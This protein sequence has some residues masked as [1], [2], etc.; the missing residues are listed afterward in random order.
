MRRAWQWGSRVDHCRAVL[1]PGFAPYEQY[2]TRGKQGPWSDVYACAATLYYL[3]TGR[4]PPEASE[5]IESPQLESPSAFAP[6]LTPDLSDAIVYGLGFRPEE[7][8]QSARAFADVIAGRAAAPLGATQRVTGYAPIGASGSAEIPRTIVDSATQLRT[9]A[10]TELAPPTTGRV[11]PTGGRVDPPPTPPLPP[12]PP[13][14][15]S[16]TRRASNRMPLFAGVA[17]LVL[18]VATAW[19][20]GLFEGKGNTESDP[21]RREEPE[22][23]QPLPVD[24]TK[25]PVPTPR[26]VEP[27]KSDPPE[28]AKPA[29]T[30]KTTTSGTTGT[31]SK[32]EI[33][34]SAR[35]NAPPPSVQNTPVTPAPPPTAVLVVMRGEDPDDVRQAE[36]AILRALV[37]R[38][39]LHA[40][41][42]DSLSLMRGDQSA[43]QAA[44]GGNF[45]ALAALGRPHGVELLVVGEVRSRAAPSINRF[46]TGTAELSVR[47]YRVSNSQIV[48]TQTFIVGQGGSQPVLAVSE[49]EA[50]SRAAAQ[51]ASAAADGVGSW[52]GR[53]F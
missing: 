19:G 4:V 40:L 42:A 10:A 22:N 44:T 39:G 35:G 17:A 50:R 5:R 28:I 33:N 20:A 31:S 37:G 51:A 14:P 8:P 47:M 30:T 38:S 1:T 29:D 34:G 52:L 26:T 49:G 11:S 25:P 24:P 6:S 53:A 15:P 18:V 27:P 41:D 36:G 2:S 12:S 23:P 3:V 13:T 45:S 16:Q 48:D 32:T 7:R 21:P 46:F 9:V 43:V